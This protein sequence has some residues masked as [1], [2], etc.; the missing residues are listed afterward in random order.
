MAATRERATEIY[1]NEKRVRTIMLEARAVLPFGEP[2]ITE[3]MK[4]DLA[5]E[6]GRQLLKYAKYTTKPEEFDRIPSV[7][8]HIRIIP[9]D[10]GGSDVEE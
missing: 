7:R 10:D 4:E 1:V 3:T 8:A 9:F 5:K 6:L 2:K